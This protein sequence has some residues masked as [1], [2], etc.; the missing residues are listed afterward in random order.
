MLYTILK[1]GAQMPFWML[2]LI[3]FSYAILIFVMLPVHE[4]AHAFVAVKLGDNTP[5]WHGRLRF[6]PL[7]HLDLWGTLLLVVFGFGYA[8]PVPVNPRNFARPKRDMA[9]TALAG[10]LSNVLIALVALLLFRMVQLA[11][12][13]Y[14]IELYA[15]LVLVDI[16]A[17]VSLSLAVFNLLP[18]PPLDGS[19]IFA[20]ILPSRWTYYMNQYQQY[21]TIGVMFLIATGALN[22]PLGFLVHY[23]GGILCAIVGLPNYF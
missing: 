9:L 15:G 10:P 1:N 18:V 4:M 12:A 14:I 8:K 13:S 19:R 23:L 7:A 6:N 20:A 3:I 16:I 21:F 17:G 2:M 5:R 22:V 11:N